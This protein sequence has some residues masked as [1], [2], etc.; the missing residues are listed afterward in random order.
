LGSRFCCVMAEEEVY[1]GKVQKLTKDNKFY[2]IE[3]AAVF[4]WYRVSARLEAAWAPEDLEIGDAVR[5]SIEETGSGAPS[6]SWVEKR[7]AKKR[8]PVAIEQEEEAD[9]VDAP[10][11]GAELY[12]G[13]VGN[14]TKDARFYFVECECVTDWY[15]IKSRVSS[16]TLFNAGAGTGDQ[17][18]FSLA[19]DEGTPR[20]AWAELAGSAA[21]KKRLKGEAPEK[22]K[23]PNVEQAA[24]NGATTAVTAAGA[25]QAAASDE[26]SKL[27]EEVHHLQK[28]KLEAQLEAKEAQLAAMQSKLEGSSQPASATSASPLAASGQAAAAPRAAVVLAAAEI[29]SDDEVPHPLAKVSPE[30]KG[31]GKA[32]AARVEGVVRFATSD[33]A[34]SALALYGTELNG[35]EV[36]PSIDPA[37]NSQI[38]VKGL[39]AGTTPEALARFFA[40]AGIVTSCSVAGQHLK[41][42]GESKGGGK[43]GF[44]GKSMPGGKNGVKGA[45]KGTFVKGG[46]AFT[47]GGSF[48]GAS[49]GGGKKGK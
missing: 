3:C 34:L 42:K 25:P 16:E 24:A 38:R 48:K 44:K 30:A 32:A 12:T 29:A 33:Q 18:L 23:K 41:G 49:K 43:A 28:A 15:K 26:L 36:Q 31:K 2:F 5:F 35:V 40:E 45:G 11:P 19:E 13:T 21:A 9:E 14:P 20:V 39:T 4:D 37:I 7:R 17:I 10:E 46:K 27:R 6:V 8:K 22:K 47:K 1:D